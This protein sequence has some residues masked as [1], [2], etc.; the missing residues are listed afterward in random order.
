VYSKSSCS[1]TSSGCAKVPALTACP[2]TCAPSFT[3]TPT[4]KGARADAMLGQMAIAHQPR[5]HLSDGYRPDSTI[6]SRP[7][8]EG[9]ESAGPEFWMARN[10]ASEHGV[11]KFKICIRTLLCTLCHCLD[12]FEGRATRPGAEPLGCRLIFIP[13]CS[14]VICTGTKLVWSRVVRH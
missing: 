11:H 9:Y 4:C 13:S 3:P 12:M 1:V 10:I 14:L 2:S 7:I 6:M 5:P 8:E